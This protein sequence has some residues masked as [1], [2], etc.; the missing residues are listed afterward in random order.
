MRRLA[1]LVITLSLAGCAGL[2]TVTSDV[3]TY[4]TWPAGRNPGTFVIERLPSQLANGPQHEALEAAARGALEQVGFKQAADAASAD[5]SVQLGARV[6]RTDYAPWGYP[7]WWG[8]GGYPYGRAGFY[9]YYPGFY[10]G[11]YYYGRAGWGYP[12][13]WGYPPYYYES[14]YDSEVGLLIR[15]RRDGTPLYEARASTA[16]YSQ[17]SAESLAAMFQ[18][19]LKD[20]PNAVPQP[21]RVAVELTPAK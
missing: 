13:G 8:W 12:M 21:H 15:D 10:P 1:P 2:N 18:A 5:V 14:Q 11:H 9:P 3:A 16:S 6:T 4:G 20:F 17:T 19:A 7:A